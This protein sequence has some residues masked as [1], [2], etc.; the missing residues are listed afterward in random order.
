MSM[1]K[2]CASLCLLLFIGACNKD[3]FESKPTLKV[4]SLSSEVVPKGSDLVINFSFTDKEGDISDT[5]FVL[6]Q[7]RNLRGPRTASP[8]P[9]RVPAFPNE[10]KGEISLRLSYVNDLTFNFPEIRIPGTNPSQYEPDSM[11]LRFVLKDKEG[12]KSDTASAS[13]V[14]LRQ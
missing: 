3:N 12:N 7:R 8:V 4:E 5:L 11:T 13:V 2:I 10:S 14:V 6:R 1:K 9:Y